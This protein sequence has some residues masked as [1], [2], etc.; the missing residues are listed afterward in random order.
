MSAVLKEIPKA[1]GL[2]AKGTDNVRT[3][4]SSGAP[5]VWITAAAISASVIIVVALL[6]LIASRGMPHF[7]PA[8][9]VLAQYQEPGQAPRP[10]HP[11]AAGRPRRGRAPG[12]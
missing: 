10:L 7:W 5:Y 9:V 11:A 3:Y 8:D 1:T 6:G 4:V 12:A 2:T